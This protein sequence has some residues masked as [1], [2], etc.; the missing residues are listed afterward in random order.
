MFFNNYTKFHYY[1]Q[2]ELSDRSAYV[3]V[4]RPEISTITEVTTVTTTMTENGEGNQNKK[5]RKTENKRVG[6]ENT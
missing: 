1:K 5:N 4:A 2:C 6:K 3:N